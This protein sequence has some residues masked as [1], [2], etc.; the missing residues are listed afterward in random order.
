MAVMS[1]S[2]GNRIG[3]RPRRARP[4]CHLTA[5]WLPVVVLAGLTSLP[6]FGAE[7]RH[8][9]RQ[10]K[11]LE[12][13]SGFARTVTAQ[14][15]VV[16]TSPEIA[17]ASE[18][19][20]LVVSWNARLAPRASLR[21][22]AQARYPDHATRFYVLGVWAL[23]APAQPRRSV[24][25]QQDEDGD[26]HTDILSLVR[27]ADRVQVRLTFEGIA[28]S[29]PT[30]LT[31]LGLSFLDTRV[32]LSSERMLKPDPL[33]P[34][35]VPERSQLLYEGGQAWCSPTAVS[36]ILGYWA[37]RCGRRDL[38]RDVP[39]VAAEVFDP[40]W[41]GTGNWPFNT[42]YAGAFPGMRGYVT[43]LASVNELG[44][45]LRRG[46]PVAASVSYSVLQGRPP[47]GDGHLVVCVG[48]TEAGDV[49]V[50]DP[51]TRH[52][53]RRVFPLADFLLA[54]A[55]SHN[56]VYVIHPVDWLSPKDSAGHW[57]SPGEHTCR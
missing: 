4:R 21:L 55:H 14:A 53:I 25:G 45:W 50:N 19:N 31:F 15:T 24:A 23:N 34:L 28:A 47:G 18:W 6:G 22:E 3:T 39:E 44:A 38:D 51:G 40:N 7:T 37:E 8:W 52:T 27:P 16:L 20:D 49:I 42:A 32:D 46:V 13:F 41:P 10:F 11:G 57:H 30:T 17:T 12:D 33:D 26:V 56:T 1:R 43:R 29:E 48:F 35:L 9:G 5:G 36:M 54:W 2:P